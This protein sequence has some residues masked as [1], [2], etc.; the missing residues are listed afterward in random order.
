MSAMTTGEWQRR[1]QRPKCQMV[2]GNVGD[3]INKSDGEWQRRKQHHDI[4]T[5]ETASI[6]AVNGKVGDVGDNVN[7]K[8]Q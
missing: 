3:N 2:N 5:S 4:S 8:R 1:R 6:K 7:E